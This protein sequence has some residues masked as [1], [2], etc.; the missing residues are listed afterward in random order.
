MFKI[1]ATITL[2]GS[3]FYA[4]HLSDYFFFPIVLAL[5]AGFGFAGLIL[6]ESK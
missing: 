2:S 5:A 4:L 1:L 3:L 6:M